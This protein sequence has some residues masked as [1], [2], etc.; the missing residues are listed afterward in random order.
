MT[1]SKKFFFKKNIDFFVFTIHTLLVLFFVVIF[2][3]VF[4]TFFWVGGMLQLQH[5]SA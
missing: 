5:A 3:V 1:M 4:Q 2:F